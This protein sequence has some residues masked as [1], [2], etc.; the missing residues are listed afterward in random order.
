MQSNV[1][2]KLGTS[3]LGIALLMMPLFAWSQRQDIYDWWRLRGY[4]PPPRI[5]ELAS[6]TTMNGYATNLFYVHQPKLDDRATFSQHCQGTEQSIV[7]GCYI[8]NRNIYIFDVQDER[9]RG[10]HEVTAAHEVL[11]AGYDRLTGKERS[12]IDALLKTFLNTLTD[13]RIKS[14]IASYEAKD[15]SVVPSEIHSIIGTEVRNLPA[16][17][18]D[19]YRRYFNDRL[20]VVSLSEQYEQAFTERKNKVTAYDKQLADLK[21]RIEAGESE[22]NASTEQLSTE[23]QRIDQLLASGQ[24]A[25]YNEAIPAYNTRVRQ[26]NSLL[27]DT[28]RLIDEYNRIVSERNAVAL[29]EQSLVEAIDTRIVPKAEQ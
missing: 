26:Y 4:N 27:T 14:T 10:I 13:E 20:K 15:P 6:A 1:V 19:Y 22:L 7:L 16:E 2:R 11:H 25:A 3:L 24:T 12:R 5:S 17:L 18:E 23:R 8:A 9:L 29:E 21:Q 28:K